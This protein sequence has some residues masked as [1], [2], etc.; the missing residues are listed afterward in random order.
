MSS[1]FDNMMDEDLLKNGFKLQIHDHNNRLTGDWI[2]FISRYSDEY[3]ELSE[4]MKKSIRDN[5][6]A[7]TEAGTDPDINTDEMAYQLQLDAVKGWSYGEDCTDE[8]K[9]LFFARAPHIWEQLDFA[10]LDK[11]L[12]FTRPAPDSSSGRKKKS[13]SKAD[14]KAQPQKTNGQSATI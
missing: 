1:I 4:R 10:F 12:F 3:K 7:A 13:T 2:L 9:R 5:V 6:Q 8:N 14:H 11:S